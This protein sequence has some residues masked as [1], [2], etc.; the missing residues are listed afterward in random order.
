M[1]FTY[2]NIKSRITFDKSL[3]FTFGNVHEMSGWNTCVSEI[4]LLLL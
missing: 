4:F 3:R 2:M 1:N